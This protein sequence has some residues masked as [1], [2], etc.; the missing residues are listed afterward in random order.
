MK[1]AYTAGLLLA[2]ASP[3]LAKGPETAVPKDKQDKVSYSIGAD[4]GNSLKRNDLGLNPDFV[5]KGLVDAL[6]GKTVLTEEEMHTVLQAFQGEMQQK[7]AAKQK[8]AGESNKTTSEKFLEENKK[9]D[10][11]KTTA[12]GLQYKVVTTGTGAMPKATDTVVVNYSGKLVNGT[13]FDSSYKRGEPATFP[14]N[15]VIPGWTEALQMM[16]VGS[17]WDL[18]IPASIAYGESAPPSIGPNQALVFTVE[19]LDIKKADKA[20]KADK[21]EAGDMQAK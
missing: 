3:V 14:V 8:V 9:K 15:G 19:L 4:V 20:D 17:K 2:I 21:A 12:S 11:V 7:M 16:P 10:G 13:E 5:A 6:N 1:L 18:A